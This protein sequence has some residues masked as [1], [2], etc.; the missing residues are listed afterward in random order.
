MPRNDDSRT[1]RKP[2]AQRPERAE[3]GSGKGTLISWIILSLVL[4]C[5][6]WFVHALLSGKFNHLLSV[7]PGRPPPPPGRHAAATFRRS[8]PCRGLSVP[9]S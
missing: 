4:L 5:L 1:Q 9:G 7:S 2:P 3:Q 8:A 6:F